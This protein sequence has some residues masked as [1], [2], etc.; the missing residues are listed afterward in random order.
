MNVEDMSAKFAK[1]FD[2]SIIRPDA[3]REDVA[4]FAETA[5]RLQTATLTV[6]PHYIRFAADLLKQ[7]GVH[8]GTVVGFP[9]GNETSAMKEY[10]AK[11]V[12]DL[13]AE[14]ID[15]VMNIPALKNGEEKLF[16][17]DV[18]GVV[19]AAEGVKV[20]VITEN[21]YLTQDEKRRAC[22]WIAQAGAHFVKTST[23]YADGGATL[24]DVR[25]MYQAVE[26]RCHVKAAGGIRKIEEILEYL[27]AGARR[28]GSTRSDQ[29]VR[30]FQE[31]SDDKKEVFGE[32]LIDLP[33]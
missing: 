31:L 12:L 15:M 8:L 29:F 7:S 27:K 18:T 26:G 2:H 5:A 4:K 11:A 13:G 28:F 24:D 32:F 6:Q 19:R 17:E 33:V 22:K 21:C 14:E 3:T 1:L 16:I 25:L 20:K 30:A 9:H 10:Q 23:A